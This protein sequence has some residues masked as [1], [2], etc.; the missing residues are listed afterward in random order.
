MYVSEGEFIALQRRVLALESLIQERTKDG[1]S[2]TVVAAPFIVV[3]IHGRPLV[4]V[5]E[6]VG[7]GATVS[8]LGEDERPGVVL[9]SDAGDLTLR[10]GDPASGLAV[11]SV[12]HDGGFLR[13]V[14]GD[15]EVILP[16]TRGPA[17]RK[18][19]QEAALA[20]VP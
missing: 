11:L 1:R 20:Q 7:D 9:C 4:R 16:S 10:L 3:G 14:A 17:L 8:L 15:E 12:D 6:S 19:F 5:E 13:L 18:A 2:G